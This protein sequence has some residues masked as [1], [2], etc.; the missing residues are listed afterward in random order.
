MYLE[1][2]LSVTISMAVLLL[3]LAVSSAVGNGFVLAI[4]ARFKKLRNYANTLIANLALVDHLNSLINLPFYLLYGVL[5]VSWFK[6]KTLAFLSSFF[7]RLF[8][9]LNL[10]SM[11]MLLVNVFLALTFD[12]RYFTWKTNEKAMAIVLVEWLVCLAVVT[13]SCLPLFE[14]DLQNA[15]VLT[16]RQVIF[17]KNKTV[18]ASSMTLFILCAIVLGTL[19][20]CSV[21]TKKLK[22]RYT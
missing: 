20:L 2:P 14:I 3:L 10:A 18:V 16:Y 11:L 12:L 15:D 4:L 6:G 9:L 19:V 8:I 5:K 7:N 1:K 21:R 17:E 22:V 13:L